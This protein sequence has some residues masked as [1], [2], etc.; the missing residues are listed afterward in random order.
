MTLSRYGDGY[1]VFFQQLEAPSTVAENM[2]AFRAA[3]RY[4]D[5]QPGW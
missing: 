3:N 5:E 4:I 2:A 1:W